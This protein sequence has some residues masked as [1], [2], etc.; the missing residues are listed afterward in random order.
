MLAVSGKDTTLLYDWNNLAKPLH[1]LD[2]QTQKIWWDQPGNT[3]VISTNDKFNVYQ[4]NKK[5]FSLTEIL[6]VNDRVT[7]GCFIDTKFYYMTKAGKIFYSFLG[8]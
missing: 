8:K 7:S 5:N 4:Y 2:Q 6:Q 1:K 3:V